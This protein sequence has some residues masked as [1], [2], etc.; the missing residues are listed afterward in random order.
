MLRPPPLVAWTKL[1][2]VICQVCLGGLDGRI[3]YG[4]PIFSGRKSAPNRHRGVPPLIALSCQG[5]PQRV[6]CFL[7]SAEPANTGSRLASEWVAL[8]AWLDSVRTRRAS[9]FQGFQV[10]CFRK[11]DV[12]AAA[13]GCSSHLRPAR[14]RCTLLPGSRPTEWPK[15]SWS[16]AR[17]WR[18]PTRPSK[19][20]AKRRVL[21]AP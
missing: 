5:F 3:G 9:F 14:H 4:V 8:G 16:T 6:I 18:L 21:G 12:E 19:P 1:C 11:C 17:P 7:M 15:S 13:R 10:R 20:A 2:D